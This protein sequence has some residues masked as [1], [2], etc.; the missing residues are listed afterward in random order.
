MEVS[1]LGICSVCS[2]NI[3]DGVFLNFQNKEIP[4][5]SNCQ[6]KIKQFD[7]ASP[8]EKE[9]T[10]NYLRGHIIMGRINKYSFHV[11][12]YC[13]G[14]EETERL[15]NIAA[16][17]SEEAEKAQPK[18]KEKESSYYNPVKYAI[19][20]TIAIISC[21]ITLIVFRN[22]TKTS[23]YFLIVPFIG[24]FSLLLS[25]NERKKKRE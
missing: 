7:T 20:L 19:E 8:L 25:S 12:D 23:I 18:P 16:D 17:A 3:N 24:L 15:I 6:D 22:G 9:Q 10:K 2:K 1:L 21:I 13:L 11:L 5:C 4:M 14:D